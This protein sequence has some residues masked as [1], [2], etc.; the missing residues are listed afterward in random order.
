[1][2]NT[3]IVGIG[4]LLLA[5]ATWLGPHRA[6]ATDGYFQ[7][8]Y[9]MQNAGM[10]GTGYALIQGGMNGA[11]NPANGS[12]SDDQ[13]DLGMY[14]FSP[15]RSAVRTGNPYGLN[16][17]ATSKSTLFPIPEIGY[18]QHLDDHITIGLSFYG[19]GGLDTAYPGGQIPAGHCGPGAPGSNLLCGQGTLGVDLTQG[20]IAPTISYKVNDAFSVGIAPQIMIQQFSA[21]GLQAFRGISGAPNDLTDRGYDYSYGAGIRLGAYWR[22]SDL[23]ALGITYQTP[24]YAT[25][26]SHYRGLFAG[27]GSFDVPANLGFGVALHVNPQ[28]IIAADYERIFYASIP[29][30]GNSSSN[31]APL[32]TASGPGFGWRDINVFKFGIAYK[33][34]PPLTLRAGF[35]HSDNPVSASNITLNLLAPGV[36]ENHFT[37]GVSYNLLPGSTFTI[38]YMHGF[39]NSVSGPTSPLLPGGGTDMVRLSEDEVGV[40]YQ[41]KF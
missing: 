30:V 20:I 5:A 21:T 6:N 3:K 12:F 10:G 22:E 38:A 9:G 7:N 13:L 14:L 34:L 24:I 32:G 28:L 18:N 27:G 23:L 36:I 33:V 11:N 37:F 19:N 2:K 1:M 17:S 16:G 29:S 31:L 41:H 25:K 35:A 4:S 39:Q 8:G 40:A 15:S 26:F